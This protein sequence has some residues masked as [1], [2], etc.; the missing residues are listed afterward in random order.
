[1]K[2]ILR[3]SFFGV[4]VVLLSSSKSLGQNRQSLSKKIAEFE[5]QKEFSKAQALCQARFLICL[6][7]LGKDHH[8]TIDAYW[9]LERTIAISKIEPKDQKRLKQLTLQLYQLGTRKT[10]KTRKTLEKADLLAKEQTELISKMF[11][12]NHPLYLLALRQR[13]HVLMRMRKFGLSRQILQQV[14]KQAATTWTHHHPM[15]IFS[16]R[17]LA[18]V[19]HMVGHFKNALTM[20][21]ECVKVGQKI[22]LP[23]EEIAKTEMD[24]ALCEIDM[25]LYDEPRQRLVRVSKELK[26]SKSKLYVPC[27]QMLAFLYLDHA[28]FNQAKTLLL[29]NYKHQLKK[30]KS[31]NPSLINSKYL[32]AKCYLGL[33]EVKLA[34][35]FYDETLEDCQKHLSD[36]HPI[37]NMSLEGKLQIARLQNNNP[38]MLSLSKQILKIRRLSFG[39]N[40]PQTQAAVH[41]IALLLFYAKQYEEA[42]TLFRLFISNR[43]KKKVFP[44][45]VLV[46]ELNL[47]NCLLKQGKLDEAREIIKRCNKKCIEIKIADPLDFTAVLGT[48]TAN[49]K[50]GDFDAA[51][52]H[53]QNAKNASRKLTLV[54]TMK[55][56]ID[57]TI[58]EIN[59]Y[60]NQYRDAYANYMKSL[61]TISPFV[62][63]MSWHASWYVQITCKRAIRQSFDG[64]VYSGLHAKLSPSEI[65]TLYGK[66]INLKGSVTN[67][68]RFYR[69]RIRNP[70][71]K[72]Q[73]ARLHDYLRKIA[74]FAGQSSAQ[75]SKPNQNDELLQLIKK[76]DELEKAISSQCADFKDEFRKIDLAHLKSSLQEN[77]VFLDFYEVNAPN[78]SSQIKPELIV[79]VIR[80]NKHTQMISLGPLSKIAKEYST[81][82]AT[83]GE[84]LAAQKAAVKLKDLLWVPLNRQVKGIK[85]I[86]ICP[87]NKIALIPLE[88]LP[89]QSG[90]SFLIHEYEFSYQASPRLFIDVRQNNAGDKKPASLLAI[91]GPAFGQ[92]RE[93]DANEDRAFL[94]IPA[95]KDE[96]IQI[97]K[98][99]LAQFNRKPHVLV[100]QQA[101]SSGFRKH[102]PAATHLHVATHSYA[103][104]GNKLNE[105]SSVSFEFQSG[106]VFAG[107]NL[108]SN[109]GEAS[110]NQWD[111]IVFEAQIVAVP[112]RNLEQVVL[113][114][115]NTGVGTTERSEGVFSLQ[116]A[117]Q[118]AGAKTVI[119]SLWNVPDEATAALMNQY[120]TNLWKKR[121][122]KGEALRAAKLWMIKNYKPKK[123]TKTRGDVVTAKKSSSALRLPPRFWASF[124]LNGDD[125]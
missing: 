53:A 116:R 76:K 13:A 42:E 23:A 7:F 92:I 3:L 26:L 87:D 89:S 32:I 15:T 43:K 67:R 71:L 95:A 45:S 120:Y 108:K 65:D 19:L 38:E 63:S 119:S 25:R 24:M 113:S 47:V 8:T 57:T 36:R 69:S 52:L 75:I 21:N 107:A 34:E 102:S 68:Q 44:K 50:T 31:Q 14:V 39:P 70:K 10:Y 104:P 101:T 98:F 82:K 35:K 122:P 100:G 83:Q 84:S 1:M 33:G 56:M 106:L 6:N 66:I 59:F 49:L 60:K 62:D 117:F 61:E 93:S 97:G 114:C 20:F 46:A 81:W 112:L 91:G 58:G 86:K 72:Y 105:N 27:Q 73:F 5:S 99:F 30:M 74:L 2:K 12:K 124:V 54:P 51:M 88:V 41:S 16:K 37:Y 40:H 4:L 28:Q 80:K 85:K 94:K 18:K 118:I 11:G 109:K 121:M 55:A 111:S 78:P 90:K 115:C 64:L 96:A 17:D 48:A 29:D 22:Q 79:F 9:D 110:T 123:T 77:E 103:H 125:G